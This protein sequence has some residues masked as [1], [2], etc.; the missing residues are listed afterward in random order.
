[1][2]KTY[3]SKCYYRDGYRQPKTINER[4]QVNGLITDAKLHNVTISPVNRLSRYIPHDWDDI[5][6]ASTAESF[7]EK[8]KF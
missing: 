2:S 7:G 8:Y 6:L 5:R 1:M 3:R 4:R